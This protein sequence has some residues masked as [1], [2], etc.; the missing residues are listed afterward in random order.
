M[1]N[2]IANTCTL[3]IS[4]IYITKARVNI[5]VEYNFNKDLKDKQKDLLHVY[6]FLYEY[7]MNK[8]ISMLY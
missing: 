1:N 3:K 2:Q 8:Y 6:V 7:I 5:S 4:H